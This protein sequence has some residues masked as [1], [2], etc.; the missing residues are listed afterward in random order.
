LEAGTSPLPVYKAELRLAPISFVR[1]FTLQNLGAYDPTATLNETYFAKTFATPNGICATTIK[2][3]EG[4]VA[5]SC[6]GP[7]AEQTLDE[8]MT[9]FRADDGHDTF[10][11]EHPLLKRLHREQRGLRLLRVPWLF[12]VACGAI[13]Q[14]RVRFA[15]AVRDWRQIALK[16]GS[17]AASGSAAF[18]SAQALAALPPWEL[19]ALG[20]DAK[21][22][23]A[24]IALARETRLHP[25]RAQITHGELRAR[26]G[27]IPGVGPWTIETTLGFGAGDPDALPLGDLYLPHLVCYALAGE[28]VGTDDRMVQLL[29]PYRGHRFRVVRLLFGA[30]I[31]VPR[32]GPSA[33]RLL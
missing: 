6:E 28:P 23:R 14:Q 26:L 5:I 25:L 21:R 15:D 9:F 18:P 12:D 33:H 8:L 13:L 19:E 10:I 24:L 22:A 4:G 11:A 27:R 17:K 32:T 20:V 7:D 30:R 31:T 16:H 1:T 2:A 3:I 29:E